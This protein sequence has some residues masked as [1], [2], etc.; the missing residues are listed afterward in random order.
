MTQGKLNRREKQTEVEIIYD[1]STVKYDRE[2]QYKKISA[3]SKCES[4][5]VWVLELNIR[6]TSC[7][8]VNMG[9]SDKQAMGI[10]EVAGLR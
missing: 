7:M 8:A 10:E 2:I 4:A 5:Y 1:Y 9:K 6:K 3:M